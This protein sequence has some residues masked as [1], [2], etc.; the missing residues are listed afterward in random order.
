MWAGVGSEPGSFW[1]QATALGTFACGNIGLNLLNSW[2]LKQH[3][4]EAPSWEHPNFTFPLFMLMFHMLL[5][6]SAAMLLIQT[7][8]RAP[9]EQTTGLPSLQQLWENKLLVISVATC[10]VLNNF[11]NLLSLTMVSL[12]VN[13]TIKA[14]MPFLLIIFSFLLAKKS[15]A[16][17][18]IA[19]V[20]AMVIGS[21]MSNWV[22]LSK[23][24]HA[25]V[26]GVTVC[27]V[28]LGASALRPVMASIVMTGSDGRPRLHPTSLLFYDCALSCCGFIVLWLCTAE[29]HES[30]AYLGA[31]GMHRTI[32]LIIIF[33]GAAIAFVF[34]L[35]QFYFIQ[36]TSA[37][38]SAFGANSVKIFMIILSA[39]LAGV[40]DPTSW[41]GVSIV[42]A[43]I[44]TYMW[45]RLRTPP[46]PPADEERGSKP[47]EATP[48]TKPPSDAK[49]KPFRGT[50][51]TR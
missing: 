31:N 3:K 43:A 30:L 23:G 41:A 5:S 22:Q 37:L 4:G 32:G 48:L 36:L 34:N 19:T 16:L 47:T 38:T 7:S 50:R 15:Y 51:G 44:L 35:A 11:F 24:S 1:Q 39:G 49:R 13:Q 9:I 14:M 27:L 40:S 6:A 12:F 45:L 29:R 21:V 33:G 46:A 25:D 26:M 17:S 10:T 42:V 8:A 2:A 28:S 20:V 18:I